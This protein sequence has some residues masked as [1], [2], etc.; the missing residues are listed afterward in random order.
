M[1]RHELQTPKPAMD[2]IVQLCVM[3]INETPTKRD[4]SWTSRCTFSNKQVRF[5]LMMLGSPDCDKFQEYLLRSD[6]VTEK[7]CSCKD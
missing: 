1:V 6:I 3:S 2:F 5:N 4:M 7:E